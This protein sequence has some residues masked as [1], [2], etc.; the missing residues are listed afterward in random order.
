M[1]EPLGAARR[2][3]AVILVSPT[4][5]REPALSTKQLRALAGR[6]MIRA[7]I[8][9]RALVSPVDWR[10]SRPVLAARRV[11][12]VSAI[13]DPSGFHAMLG[14]LE[15]DVVDVLQYADHHPYTRGD[16]Q[17]IVAAARNADLVVTTEKDLI[18][19]E[20]FPFARDSLY[21]LRVEV[22]MSDE[23]T[24]ALDELIL[25]RRPSLAQ[26]ARA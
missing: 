12:A 15:A 20:R 3:D 19:L 9:P 25:G 6:P 10:E 7:L 16:W 26:A 11:L 18:K 2:A 14:E 24:R 4:G 13:A 22:K 8:R 23:D 5:A 17:G 1:R 21:A